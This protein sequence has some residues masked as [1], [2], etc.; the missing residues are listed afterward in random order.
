MHPAPHQAGTPHLG[1]DPRTVVETLRVRGPVA[2]G[3][4]LRL[5][6]TGQVENAD[7]RPPT[8]PP[9]AVLLVRRLIDPLPGRLHSRP[10]IPRPDPAWERAVQQRLADL[11]RQA[12]R[13][14]RGRLRAEAEA[15]RFRDPAEMLACLALDLLRGTAAARWWWQTHLRRQPGFGEGRLVQLLDEHGQELPAVL[16]QLAA[17]G[18]ATKVVASF[19]PAE[20]TQLLRTLAATH[21]L[22]PLLLPAPT[23]CFP[24][25]AALEPPGGER[26]P[27]AVAAESTP[28]PPPWRSALP[29]ETA[30]GM[31]PAA[32]CLLGVALVLHHAPAR[33][34]STLFARAV[35]R[36][37]ETAHGSPMPAPPVAP[38]PDP[39]TT[40]EEP[41]IPATAEL[42]R[43]SEE[44]PPRTGAAPR[45]TDASV[46]GHAIDSAPTVHRRRETVGRK[47]VQGPSGRLSATPTVPG[48]K[49]PDPKTDPEEPPTP[50]TAIPLGQ[51]VQSLPGTEVAP[52]ETTSQTPARPLTT[53]SPIAPTHDRTGPSPPTPPPNAVRRQA[54]GRKAQ[55]HSPD[56]PAS[57]T[58][59]LGGE[60]TVRPPVRRAPEAAPGEMLPPCVEDLEDG[61]P[62]ALGGVLYLINLTEHLDLLTRFESETGLSP[63]VGPWALL[64]LLA[65]ALL[66]DTGDERHGADLLWPTLAILDGREIGEPPATGCT[67]QESLRLHRWL[68]RTVPSLRHRLAQALDLKPRHVIHHLLAV[69]GRLYVT[70]THVDLV[71]PLD[72]ISLAVRCAGLDR[73]P[74]WLP[75]YGRVVLFHFE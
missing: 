46:Q 59:P 34:R 56:P 39:K 38:K 17:W 28:E 23:H 12:D 26:L 1:A 75:A 29:T 24:H 66:D 8:M 61:V 44:S 41:S 48:A 18:E 10:G 60:S 25:R 49:H 19:Q 6:I 16:A 72:Q 15:V 30:G 5:A 50:S 11:Y 69:S 64:E 33:A 4:A 20:A 42:P 43:Q 45:E 57:A 53:S 31:P 32:E 65:R 27:P 47:A 40:L 36:W 54:T 67:G 9:A 68:V 63:R 55:N 22:S 70:R 2:Q 13:P 71:A 35:R 7:L 37:R 74:G 14:R 73:D 62:T 52:R 3:A 21:G 58:V 51:S